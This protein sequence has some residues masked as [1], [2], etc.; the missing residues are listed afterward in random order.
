MHGENDGLM[1][2]N[3]WYFIDINEIT[4]T[5]HYVRYCSCSLVRDI[6]STWNCNLYICHIWTQHVIY[7]PYINFLA[8]N[9]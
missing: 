3:Q 8:L 4:V 7:N 9:L 1:F 6:D 5:K 2:L